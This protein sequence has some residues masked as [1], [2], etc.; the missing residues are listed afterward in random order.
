MIQ[1]Q[2]LNNTKTLNTKKH[3]THNT[4]NLC[5]HKWKKTQEE[6]LVYKNAFYKKN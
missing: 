5:E 4:Q 3:N 2:N 6:E 1:I